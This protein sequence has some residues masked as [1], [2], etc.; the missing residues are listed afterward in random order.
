MENWIFSIEKFIFPLKKNVW[1]SY[2]IIEKKINFFHEKMMIKNRVSE[3]NKHVFERFKWNKLYDNFHDKKIH[4]K[5][6][7][8]KAK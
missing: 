2:K 6:S 1:N 8:F 3:R 7:R 4:D 5:K